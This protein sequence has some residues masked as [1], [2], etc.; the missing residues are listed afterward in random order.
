MLTSE[1]RVEGCLNDFRSTDKLYGVRP[2]QFRKREER[3]RYR[4]GWSKISPHRV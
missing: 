4:S 1:H 3:P 2:I